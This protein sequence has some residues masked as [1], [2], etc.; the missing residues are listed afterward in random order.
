MKTT[1]EIINKIKK[2]KEQGKTIIQIK[3]LLNLSYTITW[4]YF[5]EENKNKAIKRNCV[6]QKTHDLNRGDKYRSYQRKYHREYY[7][8]LKGGKKLK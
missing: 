8:K 1:K 3:R 7:L 5:S 2:L 6:Y 4:Y